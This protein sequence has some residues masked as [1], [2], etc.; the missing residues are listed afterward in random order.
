MAVKEDI[1]L[2]PKELR[3]MFMDIRETKTAVETLSVQMK[4]M[5]RIVAGNGNYKESLAGRLQLVEE[6]QMVGADKQDEIC[7]HLESIE[8]TLTT[9]SQYLSKNHARIENLEVELEKEK[10][11]R[12]ALETEHGK[13]KTVVDAARNKAIGIGVGAGMG[14]G[15]GLF[16]LQ[17]I[18]QS[19]AA[20]VP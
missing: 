3:E 12:R 2:T 13:L 4:D 20:S 10:G 19:L 18:I 1:T 14:T 11:K 7:N 15:G 17:Q 9:H 6:R 16:I 5:H 8:R